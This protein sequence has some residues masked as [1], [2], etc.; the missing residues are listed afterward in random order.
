MAGNA[1]LAM[2]KDP[3]KW[4]DV[5]EQDAKHYFNLTFRIYNTIAMTGD[6]SA[7]HPFCVTKVSDEYNFMRVYLNLWKYSSQALIGNCDV[8]TLEESSEYYLQPKIYFDVT[9]VL[10]IEMMRFP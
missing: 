1:L 9:R 6:G 4:P 5:T 8:F 10:E 3:L 2:S 7:E